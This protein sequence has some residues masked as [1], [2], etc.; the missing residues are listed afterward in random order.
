MFKLFKSY[1]P[2]ATQKIGNSLAKSIIK[3]GPGEKALVFALMGDLGSGKTTFLQGFAKG[4]GIKERILSPTFV[5][6]KRFT[7]AYSGR[8]YDKETHSSFREFY[9]L[10]CYRIQKLKDILGLGFQEIISDP[11]NIIVVEW[12]DR[13]RKL[14]PPRTVWVRFET[15][16]KNERTIS[17]KAAASVSGAIFGDLIHRDTIKTWQKR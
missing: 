5:I 15:A 14:L 10:D 11:R 8:S 2:Q 12:A 13:V 3:T 16:K 6:I 4:L 9:H 17:I 1:S 7:L